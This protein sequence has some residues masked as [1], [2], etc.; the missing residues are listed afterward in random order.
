M[1]SPLSPADTAVELADLTHASIA[2]GGVFDTM[3]RAVAVHIQSEHAE[4]RIKANELSTL[5]LGSIQP[6]MALALQFVLA[7]HK[8]NAELEILRTSKAKEQAQIDLLV[9]QK[10]NLALEAANIPKQGAVLDKSIEEMTAKTLNT[11]AERGVIAATQAKTETERQYIAQRT[12]TEL[13]NI[14]G[15]GV[16]P[17]SAVGAQIAVHVNQAAGLV[18]D[19]EQKAASIMAQVLQVRGTVLDDLGDASVNKFSDAD[20]GAVITKLKAG[21][22]AT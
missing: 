8:T 14:D 1:L 2:G 21:I 5:Y 10:T 16:L 7:K 6:V 17:N 15:T 13:A 11:L 20:I 18:R 3:M 19:A 4:G 12:A 22:G 9:Q